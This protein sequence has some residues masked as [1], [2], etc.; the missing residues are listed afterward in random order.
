MSQTLW[1]EDSPSL[2][3]IHTHTHPRTNTHTVFLDDMGPYHRRT[4]VFSLHLSIDWSWTQTQ[5]QSE[6]VSWLIPSPD[7][8]INMNILCFHLCFDNM[9]LNS[10]KHM[11]Y[12]WVTNGDKYAF[13]WEMKFLAT[14][15]CWPS[16][17]APLP[18]NP[19]VP[20]LSPWFLPTRTR[21]L[22]G[23]SK[24]VLFGSF[25]NTWGPFPTKHRAVRSSQPPENHPYL[26]YFI[27]SGGL[28]RLLK[29]TCMYG[30]IRWFTF[31]F[32]IYSLM[33]SSCTHS[34]SW[35]PRIKQL[36]YGTKRPP[37][38]DLTPDNCA[39]PSLHALSW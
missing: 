5:T 26:C 9:F 6:A 3:Y 23:G 1:K 30:K 20:E 36:R 11:F 16:N 39:L 24:R 37:R 21:L 19:E 22:G 8:V 7:D 2:Q 35:Q 15:I 33:N 17:E 25:Q 12:H 34:V 29:N 31:V 18:K 28:S 27:F 10:Q 13:W 4:E 32:Y 14:A 38:K